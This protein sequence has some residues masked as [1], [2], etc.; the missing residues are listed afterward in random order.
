MFALLERRVAGK[1]T[2]VVSRRKPILE[3][4]EV[5]DASPYYRSG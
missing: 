2:D 4:R 1:D 3:T 5:S